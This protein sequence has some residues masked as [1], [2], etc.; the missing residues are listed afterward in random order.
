MPGPEFFRQAGFFVVPDFLDPC[1][2][3]ALRDEMMRAPKERALVVKQDGCDYFDDNFRKADS[4]LLSKEVRAPLKDRF[5]QL[6]PELEKHFGV[7]LAG[8]EKPNFL[9]Y[10]PGD[11]FKIHSDG[12][13]FGQNDFLKLRR[14]SVVIFL[15]RE[16]EEEDEGTYGEGR[17]TFYS[18]LEGPMWERCAFA[19]NPSP[20]CLIAFPSEKLHEVTPVTHGLRF[21]VVTWYYAAA[22]DDAKNLNEPGN[23]E[24]APVQ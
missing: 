7:Q 17:L 15:N 3:S 18:L 5:R 13:R 6:L 23:L 1:A 22:A 12:G 24:L 8:Y 9:I 10:R 20:G 11:F 16:S 19:V 2:A 14:V 4:G 21:T